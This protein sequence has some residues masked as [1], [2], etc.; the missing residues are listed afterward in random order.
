[1]SEYLSA[2]AV[3]QQLKAFQSWLSSRWPDARPHAEIPLQSIL[4]NG[5]VLN[6]RIDL[7]L[8][9]ANGWVL[10]D[11][12]SSQLAMDQW[13]KLANEYC[14]QLEL[15]AQGVELVSGR[16]VIEQWLLLP[17]AGGALSIERFG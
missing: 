1:V 13:G 11:H 14:A 12:K 16:K 3:L 5:Q 8:E 9:T 2:T 6:G 4:P 7:L 10:F 17:V 15:Y